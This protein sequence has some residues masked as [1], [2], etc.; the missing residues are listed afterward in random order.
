M[1]ENVEGGELVIGDAR[2][3]FKVGQRVVP[4]AKAMKGNFQWNA[5]KPYVG[6][7][8]RIPD[9]YPHWTVDVQ[10]VGQKHP[11]G[12]HMD[13]W[14]PLTKECIAHFVWSCARC[15]Q[16]GAVALLANAGVWEG[17]DETLHAHRL[18]S[19]RCRAG[20]EDIRVKIRGKRR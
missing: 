20:A 8:K 15:R 16:K 18:Q 12:Y 4:T 2:D 1:R 6:V 10:L 7:V 17:A 11:R 13:F 3:R 19:P 9:R 14:E 5:P